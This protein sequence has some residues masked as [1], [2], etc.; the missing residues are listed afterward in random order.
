V[1]FAP[2]KRLPNGDPLPGVPGGELPSI[3]LELDQTDFFGNLYFG[4]ETFAI[5]V[6]T[7]GFD[8]LLKLTF[9]IKNK[10]NRKTIGYISAVPEKAAFDGG[11]FL[12]LRVPDELARLIDGI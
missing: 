6:P 9:P 4:I 12:S 2:S 7:P 3:G 10:S 11:F 8:P 5:F 1:K